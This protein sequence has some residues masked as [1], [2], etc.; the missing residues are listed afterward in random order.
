MTII[1][2]APYGTYASGATVDLDNATEAALVAQGRAAYSGSSPGAV[3]SPLTPV[4]QQA[5]RDN[6]TTATG[7]G[8]LTSSQVAGLNSGVIL[9]STGVQY[10]LSEV[11]PG[12]TTLTGAGTTQVV[13]GSSEVAGWYCSVAAGT[14]T[15]Y[16]NTASAGTPIIN[17]ETLVA[18]PRPIMG[19]G[20]NGRDIFATGVRVVLSGAATVRFYAAAA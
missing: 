4:E 20:T 11:L 10:S 13:T 18:G 14:I 8:S 7:G 1:L 9:S 5:L 15:V 16:D 2:S 6:G 3:F 17:A 19:A 12:P